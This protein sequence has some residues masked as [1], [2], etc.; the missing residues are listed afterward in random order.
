MGF[1]MLAAGRRRRGASAAGETG[2]MP[3]AQSFSTI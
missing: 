3:M 2:S 1:A